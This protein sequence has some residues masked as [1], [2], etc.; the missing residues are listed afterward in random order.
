[1]QDSLISMTQETFCKALNQKIKHVYPNEIKMLKFEL[2]FKQI[3]IFMCQN[4]QGEDLEKSNFKNL[5]LED[6]FRTQ[7]NM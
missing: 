4:L 3:L 1:M 5:H 6:L 7:F 2:K